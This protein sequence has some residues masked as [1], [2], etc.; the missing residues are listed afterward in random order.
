MTDLH[1]SYLGLDLAHPIVASAGPT[2]GRIDS[3]LAL[4]AAGAAAVVLPSLFEEDVVEAAARSHAVHSTGADVFAEAVSH[5]P[6]LGGPDAIDRAVERVAAAKAHLSIPVIASLNGITPGAWLG[7]AQTL[8]DAGADA[9]ELNLYIVAADEHDH[10]AA[11]ERRCVDVVT[12]V[13]DTVQLPL[14]VKVGPYFTALTHLASQLSDAGADGLVLF[15]RFAQPDID[16]DELDVVPGLTLSDSD[17]LRVPLRWIAILHGVIGGSLACSGGVHTAA[18]A[19][20]AVLAGADV[21]MT[22]SGVLR[23]GPGH[24]TTLRDGLAAWLDERDYESVAQ[25]RGSV[26]RRAVT[27]PDVYERA[28]YV[29]ALRR[30]TDRLWY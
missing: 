11:I 22:T 17:D 6:E 14:A 1:T 2:T 27:D 10:A 8:A 16:L 28:H 29:A 18:D 25:A 24:I 3:L 30:A 9:L 23:N 13:R 15:N 7:Y 5:L 20:K 21:V 19:V 12:A 26:S 4:E